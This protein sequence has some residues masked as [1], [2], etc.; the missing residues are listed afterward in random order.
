M[1]FNFGPQ[2]Y[3]TTCST[4]E[5]WSEAPPP[6]LLVVLIRLLTFHVAA[7]YASMSM[8]KERN[9]K[10]KSGEQN[11]TTMAAKSF[12]R[13]LNEKICKLHASFDNDNDDDDELFW[14]GEGRSQIFQIFIH[15]NRFYGII[16]ICCTLLALPRSQYNLHKSS[17]MS[18]ES[19][20]KAASKVF[21]PP[22][23]NNHK[24]GQQQ[25]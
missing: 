13:N 24:H 1:S 22:A 18:S 25:W 15:L 16:E 3:F 23:N 11:F 20:L 21:G 8:T 5:A 17:A 7:N 19:L 10:R 14:T 12:W 6:S 4:S 2:I 9:R